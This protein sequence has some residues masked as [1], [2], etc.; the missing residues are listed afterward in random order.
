MSL[1]GKEK[2]KKIA[3]KI[4]I[5][6]QS[7]KYEKQRFEFDIPEGGKWSIDTITDHLTLFDSDGDVVTKFAPKPAFLFG[8]KLYI[9]SQNRVSGA[10]S[11]KAVLYYDIAHIQVRFLSH[12]RFMGV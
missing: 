11:G 2:P 12:P 5:I 8:T 9:K 7:E 1:F 4:L 3:V 6:M 10:K